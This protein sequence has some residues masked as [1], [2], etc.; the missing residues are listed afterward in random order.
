MVDVESFPNYLKFH[1]SQI[2]CRLKHFCFTVRKDFLL[3]VPLDNPFS[4]T[5]NLCC[6]SKQTAFTP[7]PAKCPVTDVALNLV[8]GVTLLLSN[9][10]L[11]IIGAKQKK[12]GETQLQRPVTYDCDLNS[13]NIEPVV[14]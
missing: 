9:G 4:N 2:S 11:M 8:P 3:S 1:I 13:C 14:Q 5:L 12:R 6:S 7:R 10:T